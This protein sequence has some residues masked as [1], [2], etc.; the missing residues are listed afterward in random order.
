MIQRMCAVLRA[1][2]QYSRKESM[3]QSFYSCLRYHSG[4]KG[5]GGLENHLLL[6]TMKPHQTRNQQSN[7]GNEDIGGKKGHSSYEST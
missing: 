2:K 3:T 5:A 6:M 4:T 1:R 7:C